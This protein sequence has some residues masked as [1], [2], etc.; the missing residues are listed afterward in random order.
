MKIFDNLTSLTEFLQQQCQCY[1][2][3]DNIP[4]RITMQVGQTCKLYALSQAMSIFHSKIP[5]LPNARKQ[6]DPNNKCE[7]LRKQ[8]KRLYGSQV[9]EMYNWSELLGLAKRNKMVLYSRV[10]QNLNEHEYID[11]IRHIIETDKQPVLVFFDVSLDS[12][13]QRNGSSIQR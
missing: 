2:L 10:F 5:N 1:T 6:D 8:A 13:N 9:G 12:A 4:E 11:T 7:S 3:V